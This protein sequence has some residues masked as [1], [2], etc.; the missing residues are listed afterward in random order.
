MKSLVRANFCL[1]DFGGGIGLGFGGG[2]GGQFEA[3]F[4][5]RSGQDFGP[6]GG[7]FGRFFFPRDRFSENVSE[8]ARRKTGADEIWPN[9]AKV[10]EGSRIYK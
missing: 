4:Q 2:P 1:G 5:L 6:F 9:G 8:A 3:Q 10:K 7:R